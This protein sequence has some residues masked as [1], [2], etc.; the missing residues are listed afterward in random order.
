MSGSQ[1]HRWDE[2]ARVAIL[3]WATERLVRI[4]LTVA[5]LWI[6]GPLF[7]RS[8]AGLP[9]FGPLRLSAAPPVEAALFFAVALVVAQDLLAVLVRRSGVV[10]DG[11]RG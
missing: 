5:I 11:R 10:S 1:P 4:V 9:A 8:L 3:D 7:T 2:D 6:L